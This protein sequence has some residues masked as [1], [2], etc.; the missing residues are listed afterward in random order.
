VGSLLSSFGGARATGGPVAAGTS[1]L[2]G[3]RGPE[4]FTPSQSGAIIPNG[5]AASGGTTV[6]VH[7]SYEESGGVSDDDRQRQHAEFAKGLANTI[8]QTIISDAAERGPISRTYAGTFGLK[9][10]GAM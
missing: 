7:V 10:Q 5:A 3:E 6:N 9:R 2:V 1:Y 4:L 8:K